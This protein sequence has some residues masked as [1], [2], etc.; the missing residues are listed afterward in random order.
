MTEQEI[1]NK[2][3]EKTQIIFAALEKDLSSRF[4]GYGFVPDRAKQEMKLAIQGAIISG[5]KLAM[6]AQNGKN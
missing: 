6:E 1:K 2:M 3:L 4:T 5:Y